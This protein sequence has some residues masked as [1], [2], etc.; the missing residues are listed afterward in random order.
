MIENYSAL[1]NK[2]IQVKSKYETLQNQLNSRK[3]KKIELI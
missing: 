3:E 2:A 1:Y